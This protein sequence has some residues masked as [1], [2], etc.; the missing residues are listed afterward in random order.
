MKHL[1]ELIENL[2]DYRSK[3][4]ITYHSEYDLI[5]LSLYEDDEGQIHLPLIPKAEGYETTVRAYPVT[6]S[7][8]NEQYIVISIQPI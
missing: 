1:T 2:S 8:Y 3:Y 6:G 4:S 5:K 7:E